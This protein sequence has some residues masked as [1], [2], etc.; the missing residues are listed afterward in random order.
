MQA[1]FLFLFFFPCIT[2][3]QTKGVNDTV[4]AI[5]IQ[6]NESKTFAIISFA[7]SARLYK[8]PK[9]NKHYAYYL[10]LLQTSEKKKV[11]VVIKRASVYADTIMR[12]QRYKKE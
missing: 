10:A 7:R 8:L 11:P 5:R 2:K 9:N 1:I 3:A 4:T 6:K 12:V